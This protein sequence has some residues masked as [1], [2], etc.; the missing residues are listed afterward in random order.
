MGTDDT[1]VPSTILFNSIDLNSVD[2]HLTEVR[3][4]Q[5]DVVTHGD[6]RTHGVSV[7]KFQYGGNST[8][9]LSVEI[10]NDFRSRCE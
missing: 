5:L 8:F 7:R 3:P 1:S 4:L 6:R 9:V 10:D 2:V